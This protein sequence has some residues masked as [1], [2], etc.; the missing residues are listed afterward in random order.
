MLLC[1][2]NNVTYFHS[3]VGYCTASL[4]HSFYCLER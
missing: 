1:E 3:V 4:K 2:L